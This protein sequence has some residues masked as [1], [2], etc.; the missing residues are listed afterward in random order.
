MVR[1]FGGL[2]AR[3]SRCVGSRIQDHRSH[4]DRG[5]QVRIVS[6]IIRYKPDFLDPQNA[7]RDFLVEFDKILTINS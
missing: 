6:L 4:A 7:V 2:E 5:L 1:P 3:N